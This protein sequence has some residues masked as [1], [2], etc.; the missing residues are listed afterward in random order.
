[1]R[2]AHVIDT[3]CTDFAPTTV[4]MLA[5]LIRAPSDVFH[6]VVVMGPPN[7]CEGILQSFDAADVPIVRAPP[8]RRF[9]QAQQLRTTLATRSIDAV[10]A[11]SIPGAALA[12]AAVP[13]RRCIVTVTH[14][15]SPGRV[16]WLM[17]HRLR[18]G[19]TII[20]TISDPL[21]CALTR[22][23]WPSD[24]IRLLQPGV[25]PAWVD[26][27]RRDALRASW[28]V[29]DASTRV[30]LLM[31]DP[32]NRA[33]A[34]EAGLCVGLAHETGRDIRLLVSPQAR[35]TDRATRMAHE[36]DRA[37]RI[38]VD[39]IADTPWVA[40]AGCDAAMI[41]DGGFA[42]RRGVGASHL[43]GTTGGTLSVLWAMAAG[44]P[45]IAEDTDR[46]RAFIDPQLSGCLT[47]PGSAKAVARQL[48]QWHDHPESA[49]AWGDAARQ[50]VL[51]RYASA[52]WVDSVLTMY[53][54]VIGRRRATPPAAQDRAPVAT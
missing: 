38:I 21:R 34:T 1:M 50:M 31:G 37:E 41:L 43:A 53:N 20:S 9:L 4:A 10:H 51:Q 42:A 6:E 36:I 40:L 35:G 25:N 45:L 13:G 3:T 7:V 19:N 5:D 52:P 24:A 47:A 23:G 2:I 29:V 54:E 14:L 30:V 28:G 27:D 15:P 39:D 46:M 11:W 12:G 8:T 22:H 18:R 44:V 32:P 16:T 48:C 17:R 26:D 33:E 49:R